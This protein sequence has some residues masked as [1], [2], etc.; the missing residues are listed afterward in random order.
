MRKCFAVAALSLWAV[1][2]AAQQAGETKSVTLPGGASLELVWLP[3]GTFL[4]GQNDG[5]QDAYPNKETPQHQVT[6]SRG[7]WVG[8]YEITKQQ[9]RALMGTEP[10]AGEVRER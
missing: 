7:F 3:A 4:M 2:A 10:W 1:L 6:I 5:E 9:W 8:K